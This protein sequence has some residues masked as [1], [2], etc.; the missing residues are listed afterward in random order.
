[1]I[2]EYL[3]QKIAEA[4][5]DELSPAELQS[6]QN[7]LKKWPD[8][9][10]DFQRIMDL[11][12]ISEAYGL[13]DVSSFSHQISEIK[14][15]IDN[16]PGDEV[17]FSE[18]SLLWFRRYALAASL[19]IVA[20][21]ATVYMPGLFNESDVLEPALDEW[22]IPAESDSPADTYVLYIDDLINE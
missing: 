22:V 21:S 16:F 18:I 8:L 5:E 9:Q 2:R 7:E 6:L 1:M 14:Q 3:E 15:A 20:G 4:S 12:P 19:L 11:P 10:A 17:T 13:N